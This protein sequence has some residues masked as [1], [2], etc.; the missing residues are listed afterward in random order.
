[1]SVKA[2]EDGVVLAVRRNEPCSVSSC[3]LRDQFS[4][5]HECFLVR[6]DDVL[7]LFYGGKSREQASGSNDCDNDKIGIGKG[8]QGFDSFLPMQEVGFL[9]KGNP[10]GGRLLEASERDGEFVCDFRKLVRL[11]LCGNAYKLELVGVFS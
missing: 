8:G 2:L 5:N 1:M 9:G 6:E 3:R 11:L 10:R 4:S 7:A